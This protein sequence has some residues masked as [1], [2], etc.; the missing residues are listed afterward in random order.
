MTM[1]FA[2]VVDLPSFSLCSGRDCDIY[3]DKEGKLTIS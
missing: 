3:K 2:E 1:I